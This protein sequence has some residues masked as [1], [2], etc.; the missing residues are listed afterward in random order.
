MISARLD[1]FEMFDD[2]AHH[3]ERWQL[4]DI[5]IT[6]L[7]SSFISLILLFRRASD[8]RS[9]IGRREASEERATKLARHD[10]LT[11]L[12]N[13]RVLNEDLE[14]MLASVKATATECAVFLIVAEAD[15]LRAM[16]CDHAQGFLFG[17]PLDAAGT[18]ALLNRPARNVTSLP[19]SA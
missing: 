11:G 2:Y 8:L 6:I 10:P 13:R 15:A 12:P 1:L 4:D 19:L 9:E 14:A 5:V 3:H 7:C 17:R 16:G 18:L